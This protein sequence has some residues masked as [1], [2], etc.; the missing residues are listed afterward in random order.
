MLGEDGNIDADVKAR[1]A[2]G[3]LKWRE[4]SGVL[5]DKKMLLRL[6]GVIILGEKE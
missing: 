6:K 1:M 4:C 2:C 3:W 5:C